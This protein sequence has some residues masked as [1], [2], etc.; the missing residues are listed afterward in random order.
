MTVM[1]VQHAV[2]WGVCIRLINQGRGKR[3]YELLTA[4]RGW[5]GELTFAEGD[6]D[7]Y[8]EVHP[9]GSGK[10]QVNVDRGFQR[11]QW[12]AGTDVTAT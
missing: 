4:G 10:G 1:A 5:K 8:I 9:S 2:A 7:N 6:H 12:G 3:K 11:N